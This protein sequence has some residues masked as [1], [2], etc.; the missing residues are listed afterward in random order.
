ML[1]NIEPY[2]LSIY[3]RVHAGPK[4]I[5]RKGLMGTSSILHTC[6]PYIM[7]ACM[8]TYIHRY[9]RTYYIHTYVIHTYI[10]KGVYMYI[11][12][13][14]RMHIYLYC[15]GT[16]G[17]T[18]VLHSCHF[19]G[20]GKG[21]QNTVFSDLAGRGAARKPLSERLTGSNFRFLRVSGS[22]M[23]LWMWMCLCIVVYVH[24]ITHTVS[25]SYALR[26][27]IAN[28]NAR[29]HTHSVFELRAI[30]DRYDME[31]DGDLNA[32]EVN[33]KRARVR[34]SE[35]GEGKEICIQN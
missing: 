3:M 10:D 9:I 35:E 31:G 8:H 1:K 23:Y 2:V 30:F 4:R 6:I 17:D 21:G 15:F 5:G 34:A 20:V 28:Y 24:D 27:R 14:L 26:V 32:W 12:V 25:L 29:A 18:L 22:N 13:Q 16:Y 19:L 11:N 33:R 7:H